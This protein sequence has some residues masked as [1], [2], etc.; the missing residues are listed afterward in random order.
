MRTRDFACFLGPSDAEEALAELLHVVG[1]EAQ[2]L[3][4]PRFGSADRMLLIQ[5]VTPQL[6]IRNGRDIRVRELHKA[7]EA[8]GLHRGS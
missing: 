8:S 3:E 5:E 7:A 1:A 4:E 2:L 6:L